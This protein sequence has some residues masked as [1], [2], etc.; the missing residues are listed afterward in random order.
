MSEICKHELLD[1]DE[2]LKYNINKTTVW[3]CPECGA[4][5]KNITLESVDSL[6]A[7]GRI[8]E[9]AKGGLHVPK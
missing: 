7:E 9:D 6:I 2:K 1:W 3:Y 4:T 5:T 8:I